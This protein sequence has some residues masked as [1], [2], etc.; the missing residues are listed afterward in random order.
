ML[1]T[2][3]PKLVKLR[4]ILVKLRPKLVKVRPIGQWTV[5]PTLVEVRT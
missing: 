5:W 3:R 1:V 4:P 2:I